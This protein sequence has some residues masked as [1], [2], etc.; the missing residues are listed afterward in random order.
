[1]TYF[2]VFGLP[3]TLRIDGGELQAKFYELSRRHHPDF[4]Q[5]AS[6]EE[7][8]RALT[9][10]ALV[11]AAYRTLRDPIA[12]VDY[13][14]RLEEGRETREG[15]AMK[16][17]A[18]PELLQEIFEIQEMLEDAKAGGLDAGGRE[19]LAA[20]RE[21]LAARCREEEERLTGALSSDWDAAVP[22]DR[23]R[24]VTAFKEVLARRAY[25]R[26]VVDDL[27]AALDG[28][29]ESDVAHHRH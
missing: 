21:R 9:Q 23:P 13:L 17:P 5:A 8:A 25:L 19:Q 29:E 1:M 4:Q 6:H 27:D 12:R 22:S 14:V 3:R 2:E 26:T 24:L 10:S 7:Q 16:P 28:T 11:N 15:S 18:P 20:E